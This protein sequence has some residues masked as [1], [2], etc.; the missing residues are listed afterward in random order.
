MPNVQKTRQPVNAFFTSIIATPVPSLPVTPPET[1]SVQSHNPESPD[2]SA[3]DREIEI[4]A[5]TP[6][7]Q[8]T[9]QRNRLP[10]LPVSSPGVGSVQSHNP[11]S[12]DM[13]APHPMPGK[14]SKSPLS[15]PRTQR[16]PARYPTTPVEPG[17][18]PSRHSRPHNVGAGLKPAPPWNPVRTPAVIPAKAGTQCAKHLP[19]EVKQ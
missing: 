9:Q 3:N 16:R 19:E 17:A 7:V 14:T 4:S 2:M 1:G 6:N 8:K 15:T 5:L 11:E 13:S 10:E 18:E 12:P